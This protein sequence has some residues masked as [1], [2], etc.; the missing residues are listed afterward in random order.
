M[1]NAVSL[2]VQP[3][4]SPKV[5]NHGHAPRRTENAHQNRTII[6][7]SPTNRTIN[8]NVQKSLK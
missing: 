1:A 4:I 3:P 2:T 5:I 7:N 6:Q 8:K